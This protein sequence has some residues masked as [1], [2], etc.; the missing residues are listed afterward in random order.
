MPESPNNADRREQ[1]PRPW[2]RLHLSTCIVL[3]PLTAV[4]VLVAVPGDVREPCV[5][6]DLSD[7]DDPYPC[8][9]C[10]DHGWPLSYLRRWTI[11]RPGTI[12][13]TGIPWL[14]RQNWDFS[15]EPADFNARSLAVDVLV[16]LLIFVFVASVVE[17]RRRGLRNPWQF[18]L[19][20]LLAT[21]VITAGMLG[22]WRMHQQRYQ[23]ELHAA[24]M[25]QYSEPDSAAAGFESVANDPFADWYLETAYCGPVWLRKLVPA[26]HLGVFVTVVS[27]SGFAAPPNYGVKPLQ[28]NLKCFVNLRRL[29]LGPWSDFHLT[30]GELMHLSKLT[31]LR[32]LSLADKLLEN[33]GLRYLTRLENLRSLNLSGTSLSDAGLAHLC[34]LKSLESLDLCNTQV[35][36]EG[37]ARLKRALPDCQI[38]HSA[39]YYQ[40]GRPDQRIWRKPLEFCF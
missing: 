1:P 22:W 21:F 31:S 15:G 27:A 38:L 25:L 18:R 12:K 24:A 13:P 26:E 28:E 17:R 14:Q 11:G 23:R 8:G 35:T 2:Y 37:I 4:L 36:D 7:W 5:N 6:R 20:E 3:L 10:R 30:S 29:D 40:R 33:D 32:T 9:A 16:A 19:W 39:Q 34:E